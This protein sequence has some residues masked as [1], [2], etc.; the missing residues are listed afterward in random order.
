[1]KREAVCSCGE[2]KVICDGEPEL[3]S[4]CHCI[5]C[6]RRSGSPFGVA[7]FFFRKRID[8]SGAY[9]S[10][11]RSSD[12]GFSIDFHFCRRCGSS[13]FWEPSRKPDMVAVGVGSFGDPGFPEPSQEVYTEWRHGWIEPLK[14]R[15]D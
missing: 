13:V 11:R 12:A 1:M 5:A 8:V 4:R 14:R 7:A 6:Q 10:Y 15:A 9:E 3:I 2:L